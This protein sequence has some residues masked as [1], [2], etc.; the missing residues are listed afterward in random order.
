MIYADAI[1]LPL[2]ACRRHDTPMMMLIAFRRHAAMPP[3]A[4]LDFFTP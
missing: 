3:H 2:I 4:S 1:T